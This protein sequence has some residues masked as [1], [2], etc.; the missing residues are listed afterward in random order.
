MDSQHRHELEQNDLQEFLAHFKQWWAK[1]GQSVMIIITVCVVAFA[2]YRLYRSSQVREHDAAWMDLATSTSPFSYSEVAEKHSDPTVRALAHLRAGDLLRKQAF[3]PTAEQ[4][5]NP[6][7]ERD[8]NSAADH[9]QQ[10]L[11][12]SPGTAFTYNAYVGLATVEESRS[13]FDAARD[14]YEKAKAAAAD[15][16][17]HVIARIDERIA[18]IDRLSQPVVMVDRPEDLLPVIPDE[19]NGASGDGEQS[20]DSE[21]A[22]QDGQAGDTGDNADAGT[23]ATKTTDTADTPAEPAD[24]P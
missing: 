18:T 21:D 22:G 5:A 3:V 24:Q 2:G 1:H 9:Y 6:D 4:D 12:N 15:E 19:G 20:T 7:P 23:D 13:N 16:M 8:L 17:P 11:D 10:V 14:Y